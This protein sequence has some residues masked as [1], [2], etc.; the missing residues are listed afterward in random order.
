MPWV[1]PL[2]Q[3]WH[4]GVCWVW[5]CFLGECVA[6]WCC[7][8]TGVNKV[9]VHSCASTSLHASAMS[10]GSC[11]KTPVTG[12]APGTTPQNPPAATKAALSNPHVTPGR[13]SAGWL[14][15]GNSGW[16][17][18]CDALPVGSVGLQ[19]VSTTHHQSHSSACMRMMSSGVMPCCSRPLPYLGSCDAWCVKE[20][21]GLVAG[22]CPP[23]GLSWQSMR[24]GCRAAHRWIEMPH[25][26]RDN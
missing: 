19:R 13:R 26:V 21:H 6:W 7:A 25:S 4:V 5:C 22:A 3:P 17:G 14:G 24:G 1:Q 10:T 9:V 20:T 12:Q 8:C 23:C 11:A 15:L 2:G 16:L 18:Y